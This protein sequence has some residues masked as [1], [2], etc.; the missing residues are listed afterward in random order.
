MIPGEDGQVGLYVA[1]AEAGGDAGERALPDVPAD[2]ARV[3]SI[4]RHDGLRV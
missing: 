1:L 4:D 3:S 2:L